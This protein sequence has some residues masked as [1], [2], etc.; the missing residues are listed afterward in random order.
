ME[1]R[2]NFGP[3]AHIFVC[4]NIRDD[5]HRDCCQRVGGE[6]VVQAL[7]DWVNKESLR[8]KIWVS[9]SKCLGFCNPVG[10]TVVVYPHQ[11]WFMQV[12]KEDVASVAAQVKLLVSP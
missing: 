12:K 1:T 2:D 7:K 4:V 8:D 10:A 3:K 9:K 5:P 11:K 6:E